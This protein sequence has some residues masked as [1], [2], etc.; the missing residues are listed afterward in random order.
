[1]FNFQIYVHESRFNSASGSHCV[2]VLD[3]DELCEE[4]SKDHFKAIETSVR[5]MPEIA[6]EKKEIKKKT[7]QIPLVYVCLI[8]VLL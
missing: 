4:A 6:V 5:P 3:L 1:M 7:T 2:N 8:K